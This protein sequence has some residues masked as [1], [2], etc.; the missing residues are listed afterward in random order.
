MEKISLGKIERVDLRTAWKNEAH[1]FTQWLAK[2]ENLNILGEE[3]GLSLNVLNTEGAVGAFKTD[4]VAEDEDGRKAIIENQLEATDHDHLGKIITY[5][6]GKDA[7]IMIWITKEARDEHKQ[8]VD[9]LN[10]HGDEDVN[11][12]LI[13]MELWRIGNSD[14]APK[15]QVVS[16][17]NEWTK[18]IKENEPTET[19]IMQM[20]FWE[21][22]SKYAVERDTSLKFRKPRPQ[23]WYDVSVGSSLAH[24][25]FTMNTQEDRLS[26]EL[27]IKERKDLFRWL[28][29]HKEEIEGEME[30]RLDWM[31]LPNK[32]AS[33]IKITTDASFEDTSKWELS[34]NWLKT[35]GE[36]FQRVFQKYIRQAPLD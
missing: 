16:K 15:F 11:F 25:S 28:N 31:E 35:Q 10:L 32:K 7:K 34:F 23:H 24:I 27:N 3:I 5:A 36:K 17:P 33:R 13:K 14:P 26:C 1:D 30:E 8:A 6:S 2:P 20:D 22:F 4:I 12:F 21:K 19:K 18:M 29:E 9:W